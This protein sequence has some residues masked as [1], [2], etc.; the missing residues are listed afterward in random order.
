M[1]SFPLPARLFIW[2]IVLSGS[3]LLFLVTPSIP[4]GQPIVA[5]IISLA[6]MGIVDIYR[7]HLPY[8]GAEVS[9]S[10]SVG[11]AMVLLF[12]PG[13]AC[14]AGA[15]AF[16][17]T[18]LYL[19]KPWYKALFNSA[20]GVLSFGLAGLAYQSL[21]DGSGFV[22]SSARNILALLLA[23]AVCLVV[24][25]LVVSTIVAF[26]NQQS[27]WRVWWANHDG[28][29]LQLLTLAPLGTLMAITYSLLI[30]AALTLVSLSASGLNTTCVIPNL[31]LRST[32]MIPP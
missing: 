2:C 9:V 15:I 19:K 30:W 23:M 24:N 1:Q 16:C 20:N 5:S 18:D 12:G 21:S 3:T 14:W 22:L 32:K 17:L 6:L 31:S 4:L 28:V 26:L 25:T 11:F 13:L 10:M 27:P 7:V 29:L 8:Y